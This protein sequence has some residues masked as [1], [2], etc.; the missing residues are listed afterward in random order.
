M[1]ATMGMENK[2][3]I[4]LLQH[5]LKIEMVE[6]NRMTNQQHLHIVSSMTGLILTQITC[7]VYMPDQVDLLERYFLR[8]ND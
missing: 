8:L 3:S 7:C 6:T 2:V 4:R 1:R 5:V